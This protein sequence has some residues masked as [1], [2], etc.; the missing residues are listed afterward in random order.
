MV[1][2]NLLGPPGIKGEKGVGLGDAVE[3]RKLGAQFKVGQ[4][5][6]VVVA[7]VD[8]VG[9]TQNTRRA[10]GFGEARAGE[11]H[12]RHGILL[13]ANVAQRAVDG[14][15]R[16]AARDELGK[17]TRTA[18]FEV[19]RVRRHHDDALHIVKR[20]HALDFGHKTLSISHFTHE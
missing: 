14:D 9:E 4:Q 13:R 3:A 12:A 18:A 10:V 17:R 8:R 6:A 5:F 7:Q 11:G 16:H 19:I 2:V 15:D 1:G 20:V